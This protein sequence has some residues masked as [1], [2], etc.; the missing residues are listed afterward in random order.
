[1]LTVNEGTLVAQPAPDDRFHLDV[2]LNAVETTPL[3]LRFENGGLED[4]ATLQWTP[5]SLAVENDPMILR[6]GETLQLVWEENDPV[7]GMVEY[8]LDDVLIATQPAD[9]QLFIEMDTAGVY[10]F[11]ASIP[12]SIRSMQLDVREADL[13]EDFYVLATDDRTWTPPD[14]SAA[15]DM[16]GDHRLKFLQI[17]ESPIQYGVR[18]S[19]PEPRHIAVRTHGAGPDEGA[20]STPWRSEDCGWPATVRSMPKRS[21]FTRTEPA[22]SPWALSSMKC[23]RTCRWK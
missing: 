8:R 10:E 12:G 21:M 14:V 16:E 2:P 3:T 1:M 9:E 4:S 19:V 23:R 13:G 22:W 15:H 18:S 5:Y 20:S 11:T 7:S 17:S 6:K